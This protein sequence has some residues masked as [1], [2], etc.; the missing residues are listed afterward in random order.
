M[1]TT[2]SGASM[3]L[4]WCLPDQQGTSSSASL[5]TFDIFLFIAFQI[6]EPL[7]QASKFIPHSFLTA[8]GCFVAFLLFRWPA[9]LYVQ[10]EFRI[11]CAARNNFSTNHFRSSA[12]SGLFKA[13]LMP[14]RTY[15]LQRSTYRQKA[16]ADPFSV[17]V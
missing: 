7:V 4:L 14:I 17:L 2:E 13:C 11:K 1:R 15:R 16:A 3:L 8:N 9:L 12:I 10:G 5:F 6:L